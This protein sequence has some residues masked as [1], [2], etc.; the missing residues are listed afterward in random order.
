MTP[1]RHMRR[2]L[3]YVGVAFT[4]AG[5]NAQELGNISFP[6]SGN[7]A[8]QPKFIEGVKD[9]HS[10]EFD[11]AAEAFREAQQIDPNFALAYWGEALSYNHPLWAQLDLPASK[12]ALERLAPTLAGRLAKAHTEKEKAFLEAVNQLFYA[13]GDKLARDKAY[14]DA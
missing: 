12:K 1:R 10:F 5:L 9:L 14:S 13:P 2:L 7:A 11:E 6:T 8:A 4:V 3:L